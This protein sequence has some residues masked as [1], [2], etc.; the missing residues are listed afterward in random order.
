MSNLKILLL[1]FDYPPNHGIGGRRWAKFTAELAKNGTTTHV[2]KAE[3]LNHLPGSNWSEEVQHDLIHV[4]DVERRLPIWFT[5]PQP[6]IRNKL[7][8]HAFKKWLRL[9]EKGGIYD[10]SI[11]MEEALIKRCS[12]LIEEEKITHLIA[13]GAPF[14]LLVTAAKLKKKYPHLFFLA[15]Y[16]DPWLTAK[17]YGMPQLNDAQ[18]TVEKNKQQLVF[19]Q[20]NLITSPYKKLTHLT[21]SQNTNPEVKLRGEELGHCFDESKLPPIRPQ[22]ESGSFTLVYGGAFYMGIEKNLK[23]LVATIEKLKNSHPKLHHQLQVKIFSD[24]QSKFKEALNGHHKIQVM[25][26][27]GKGLFEE[28]DRASASIIM[29]AEHNKDFK[30]SKFWEFAS[31]RKPIAFIGAEGETSQFIEENRMGLHVQKPEDL[32]K[33]MEGSDW[34]RAYPIENHTLKHICTEL[35]SWMT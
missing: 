5:H 30:T 17:N 11:G 14:N 4:H 23:Q 9:K 3:Q 6:G 24:D 8:F 19:E 35:K 16:R 1:N 2:V 27:I 20:A 13:T 7:K 34:N 18:K 15:D 33:F 21:I 26:S 28:I 31:R 12:E 29:L 32:A 10:V 25:P 22:M